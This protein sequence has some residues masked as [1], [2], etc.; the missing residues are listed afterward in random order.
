MRLR[1]GIFE[2]VSTATLRRSNVLLLPLN[3]FTLSISFH[4]CHQGFKIKDQIKDR[5]STSYLRPE[6]LGNGICDQNRQLN[7]SV[8]GRAR[9]ILYPYRY[10]ASAARTVI[11]ESHIYFAYARYLCDPLLMYGLSETLRNQ[12]CL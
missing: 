5:H 6:R 1:S 2:A 12:L 3:C 10:A 7:E 11:R 9:N 4:F 8:C